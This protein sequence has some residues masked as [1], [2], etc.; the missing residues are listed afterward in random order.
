MELV[1]ERLL[2]HICRPLSG[3]EN[4][5]AAF[6]GLWCGKGE[7]KVDGW[8]KRMFASQTSS[9]S[10]PPAQTTFEGLLLQLLPA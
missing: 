1:T 2:W 10:L 7:E 8:E 3:R 6:S 4:E 9:I 5:G